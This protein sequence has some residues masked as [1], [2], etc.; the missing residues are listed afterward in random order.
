L[1]FI[2]RDLITFYFLIY[3]IENVFQLEDI[4]IKINKSEDVAR[5]TV[6]WSQVFSLLYIWLGFDSRRGL[7]MFLFT[8]ASEWPWDPPSLLSNGY[9][10]LSLGGKAAGA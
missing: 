9:Q 4:I 2:I 10:G 5:G 8:T 6:L 3:G 1:V 7:R